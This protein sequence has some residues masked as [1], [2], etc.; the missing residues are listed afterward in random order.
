MKLM[1]CLY[2]NVEFT[3]RFK[4][5]EAC[6]LSPPQPATAPGDN[7]GPG[8]IQQKIRNVQ[9]NFGLCYF[10]VLIAFLATIWLL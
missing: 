5:D 6:L 8:L 2:Q 1:Y 7:T 3:R 4:D 9:K 10:A